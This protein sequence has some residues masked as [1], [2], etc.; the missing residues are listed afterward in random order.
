MKSSICDIIIRTTYCRSLAGNFFPRVR[1]FSAPAGVVAPWLGERGRQ[2]GIILHVGFLLDKSFGS[3]TPISLAR[4]KTAILSMTLTRGKRPAC[5]DVDCG[6]V[7]ACPT[8]DAGVYSLVLLPE[9]SQRTRRPALRSMA[10][11]RL[12]FLRDMLSQRKQNELVCHNDTQAHKT[13][14]SL[15]YCHISHPPP[16]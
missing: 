1:L 6:R 14:F 7:V 9:K 11:G 4:H 12:C 2:F 15:I 10:W 8:C 5:P 16:D 13:R 3:A